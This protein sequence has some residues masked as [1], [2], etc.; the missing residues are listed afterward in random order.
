M[1]DDRRKT[2]LVA[3]VALLLF[4]A[5]VWCGEG[6]L[7]EQETF[8]ATPRL[9]TR[10]ESESDKITAQA[11]IAQGR[12]WQGEGK[13]LEA[14]RAYQRA[15]RYDSTQVALLT[16]IA[17]LAFE[18]DRRHEAMTYAVLAAEHVPSEKTSLRQ[19]A[20]YLASEQ[21]YARARTMAHLATVRFPLEEIKDPALLAKAIREEFACAKFYFENGAFPQVT[22]RLV[23]IQAALS[24]VGPLSPKES[25]QA[26]YKQPALVPR[27]EFDVALAQKSKA[28]GEV[29]L[30]QLRQREGNSLETI[31]R[32]MQFAQAFSNGKADAVLVKRWEDAVRSRQK[33]E[34]DRELQESVMEILFQRKEWPLLR[35]WHGDS[36]VPLEQQAKNV[37]VRRKLS[38]QGAIAT[39]DPAWFLAEL[40]VICRG[41]EGLREYLLELHEAKRAPEFWKRIPK[42]LPQR[43]DDAQFQAFA[44]ARLQFL[45]ER[46]NFAKQESPPILEQ[47]GDEEFAN[48]LF[49][50]GKEEL[51]ANDLEMAQMLLA[52]VY[53]EQMLQSR[54]AEV[55]SALAELCLLQAKL[56]EAI[57]HGKKATELE[58]R[59]YHYWETLTKIC[60]HQAK[61]SEALKT[62]QQM[63]P[64]L[65][66]GVRSLEER[67]AWVAMKLAI[68]QAMIFLKQNA[69]ADEFYEMLLDEEP[70]NAAVLNA[71][72]EYF[73]KQ[74]GRSGYGLRLCKKAVL[75]HPEN[76]KYFGGFVSA[77]KTTNHA[78]FLDESSI[79]N[80]AL[81]NL[82]DPQGTNGFVWDALGNY[83][84][85][86]GEKAVAEKAWSKAREL[87]L[88]AGESTAAEKMMNKIKR[89]REK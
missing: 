35:A 29:A 68:A 32:E 12:V 37:P 42:A 53:V 54:S 10:S 48:A 36:K 51:A 86:F 76:E 16:Q 14:M 88:L 3:M 59:N 65:S 47:Q 23:S 25:E 79:N 84:I 67:N 57:S 78:V 46:E 45:M 30:Q 60:A 83:W 44:L 1:T 58:P 18:Q 85:G 21:E 64:L 82:L 43:G 56:E 39:E 15:W 41:E 69:R 52:K 87:F 61:W 72:G 20:I 66:D 62:L 28:K 24:R 4:P 7:S 50:W 70:E 89:Y 81:I 34:M 63:E 27:L 80:E 13:S 9:A 17:E 22:S 49:L 71:A 6:E 74:S 26:F 31:L 8:A 19:A 5:P 11:L 33:Q 38:L 73:V 75:V 2:F 77:A 55:E 40:S